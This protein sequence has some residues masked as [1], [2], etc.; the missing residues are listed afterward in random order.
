MKQP[1]TKD[2][3]MKKIM[4]L[5]AAV[6]A[7]QAVPA[8]AEDGAKKMHRGDGMFEKQDTN[9]DGV[10]SEAEFLDH[11]KAK[12]K[13]LDGNGDGNVTKDEAKSH[14]EKKRADWKAKKAEMK[15][16]KEAAPAPA[17]AE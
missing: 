8:M 16:K 5:S 9:K 17:P 6:L 7:L 10:I 15:A 13:E 14:Y 12:F 2:I 11:G 3:K 4:L 1:P